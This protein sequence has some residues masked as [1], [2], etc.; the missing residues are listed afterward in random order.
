LNSQTGG[1]VDSVV[2]PEKSAMIGKRN[3]VASEH[4]PN[5][6]NAKYGL[7]STFRNLLWFEK[8]ETNL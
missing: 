3:T 7:L 6:K 1:F 4:N 2:A 5:Q 8:S